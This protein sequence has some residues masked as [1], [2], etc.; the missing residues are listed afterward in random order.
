MENSLEL[1]STFPSELSSRYLPKFVRKFLHD[2]PAASQ[3]NFPEVNFSSGS[4]GIWEFYRNL[5]SGNPF[6]N[7]FG[8][9]LRSYFG[10]SS[11]NSCKYF[12]KLE[13]KF[14]KEV[15]SIIL[16]K[17]CSGVSLEI[18]WDCHYEYFLKFF[19]S[20]CGNSL[21]MLLPSSFKNLGSSYRS[22]FGN[23]SRENSR[24]SP[25]ISCNSSHVNFLGNFRKISFGN[26]FR[27]TL[28]S[29]LRSFI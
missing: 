14:F 23:S 29:L 24:S 28:V 3:T 16:L 6:K 8:K 2:N 9:F 20:F 22:S 7:S 25:H 18:L 4:Y 5:F 27:S 26:S 19:R 21:Q 15:I 13:R 10:S 1:A 11:S 12:L 17:F